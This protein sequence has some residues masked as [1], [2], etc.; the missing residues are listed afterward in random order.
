MMVC[1]GCK[2]AFN[3]VLAGWHVPNMVHT[4][5]RFLY[6]SVSGRRRDET[7]NKQLWGNVFKK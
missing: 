3:K 1:D 6:F 2:V 4:R 7:P 5:C